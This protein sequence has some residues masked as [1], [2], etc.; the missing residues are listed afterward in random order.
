M[1]NALLDYLQNLTPQILLLS[2][3]LVLGT[4]LNLNHVVFTAAGVK[5]VAPYFLI[6]VIFSFAFLFNLFVFIERMI[7]TSE[8]L[9]LEAQR[10]ARVG[11][12]HLFTRL[13]PL[14]WTHDK[15][16]LAK[17]VL[18]LFVVLGGSVAVFVSAIPAAVSLLRAIGT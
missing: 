2:L 5:N 3:A 1:Q 4:R 9:D 15:L 16:L 12:V 14:V 7:E 18:A 8:K 13:I 17:V 11:K 6:P 10:A